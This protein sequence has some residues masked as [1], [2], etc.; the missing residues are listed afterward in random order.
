MDS[1][2]SSTP[3][4]KI[5]FEFNSSGDEETSLEIIQ[6]NYAVL[7]SSKPISNYLTGMLFVVGASLIA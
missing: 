3:T 5:S 4:P 7:Q 1:R 2:T 6:R